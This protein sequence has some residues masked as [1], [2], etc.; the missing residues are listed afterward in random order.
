MAAER[1]PEFV[2][3]AGSIKLSQLR[4]MLFERHGLHLV[5]DADM[6][7]LDAMAKA[8]LQQLSNRAE[9]EFPGNWLH[10]VCDAELSRRG[11]KT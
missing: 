9:L 1:E 2:T 5:T 7:V 10:D 11:E 3:W 4:E 8:P 6:R